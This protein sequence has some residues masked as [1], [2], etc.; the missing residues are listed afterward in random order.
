M[1]E[2]GINMVKR[3]VERGEDF[4]LI[5]VRKRRLHVLFVKLEGG[6]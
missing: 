5:Q 3:E 6:F 2:I 4:G 1:S